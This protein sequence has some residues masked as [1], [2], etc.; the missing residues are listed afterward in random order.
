MR[1]FG[2]NKEQDILN[3]F[4]RG[5]ASAMDE[6]YAEYASYL[7]AICVRYLS[8]DDDV[9]DVLQEAFIKIFTTID[10]FDYRGSGSLKAW[11]GRRPIRLTSPM[12][13]PTPMTLPVKR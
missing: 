3:L 7:T 8:D 11:M 2:R 10:A 5:D 1:I 4:R 9:K 6:L 13:I 12:T